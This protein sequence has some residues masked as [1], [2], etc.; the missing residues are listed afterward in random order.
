MWN[1]RYFLTQLSLFSPIEFFVWIGICWSHQLPD[2]NSNTLIGFRRNT[3]WPQ[4][5]WSSVFGFLVCIWVPYL[6]A[7]SSWLQLLLCSLFFRQTGVFNLPV[8]YQSLVSVKGLLQELF[9]LPWAPFPPHFIPS[10]GHG[11]SHISC[12]YSGSLFWPLWPAGVPS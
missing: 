12:S 10:L 1:I 9:L 2:W 3:L 8:I 6:P 7:C 4:P 5:L 11:R